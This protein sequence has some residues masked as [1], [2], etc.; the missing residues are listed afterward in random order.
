MF[1]SER[2]Q[3]KKSWIQALGVCREL[4]AQLLSLASYEEEH[5]VANMLNKI[6]GYRMG[7]VAGTWVGQARL[8]DSG[9][10]HYWGQKAGIGNTLRGPAE[11][12][13]DLYLSTMPEPSCFLQVAMVPWSLSRMH[14]GDPLMGDPVA[15]KR[16]AV[17]KVLTDT[18]PIS[19][20]PSLTAPQHVVRTCPSINHPERQGEPILSGKGGRMCPDPIFATEALRTNL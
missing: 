6:F 12:W 1:S 7:V 14:R 10:C 17:S 2:L 16:H 19:V 20:P 4:G 13:N 5:F 18:V 15:K 11:A 9:F 8:P 3:E